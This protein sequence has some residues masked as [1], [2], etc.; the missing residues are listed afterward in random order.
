LASIA[1]QLDRGPLV[2]PL[3]RHDRPDTRPRVYQIKRCV[4]VIQRH[5]MGDQIIDIDLAVHV[6]LN[7]VT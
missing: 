3:K 5:D 6:P 4:D 2:R 7:T 1:Q